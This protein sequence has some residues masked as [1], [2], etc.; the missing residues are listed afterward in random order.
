MNFSRQIGQ[1]LLD[2]P[3]LKTVTTLPFFYLVVT[4]C[5]GS[6]CHPPLDNL[7]SLEPRNT[8]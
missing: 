6:G 1:V 2:L 8:P 5:D 3:L 4:A 7:T